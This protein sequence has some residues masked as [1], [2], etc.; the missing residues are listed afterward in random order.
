M[1][2]CLR[3]A[4]ALKRDSDLQRDVLR[5]VKATSRPYPGGGS[6]GLSRQEVDIAK[7]TVPSKLEGAD[8]GMAVHLNIYDVSHKSGVQW[9]NAVLAH[10]MAPVKLGGAFHAGV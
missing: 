4:V 5:K 3:G 1:L 10:W 9:F 6:I 7:D 2:L 8:D